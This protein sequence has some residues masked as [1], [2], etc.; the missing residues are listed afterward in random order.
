M[1]TPEFESLCLSLPEAEKGPHFENVAFKVK[2][3][4]F[5]TLNTKESRA[6][7]KFKPEEQNIYLKINPEAIFPVPNKWG[8]H[9]WTHLL[10]TQISKEIALELLKIAY[11]S[12]A[13]PK[14]KQVINFA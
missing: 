3:K 13:P 8:K 7:L 1:S 2:G 6:T 14:L 9:G 4:I 11:V 5:A 12:V 10:Y